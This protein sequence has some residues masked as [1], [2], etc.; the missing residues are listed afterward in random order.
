MY[1]LLILIIIIISMATLFVK[2]DNISPKEIKSSSI[3]TSKDNK[4]YLNNSR[5]V[6][7]TDPVNKS[8]INSPVINLQKLNHI[9]IEDLNKKEEPKNT[10]SPVIVKSKLR[11]MYEQL[12][13]KHI[14]R[15]TK[16]LLK[17]LNLKIELYVHIHPSSSFTRGERDIFLCIWDNINNKVFDYD[18]IFNVYLHELSHVLCDD[19]NVIG[20]PHTAEF[21]KIFD[22][23]TL[24]GEKLNLFDS[25]KVN[26]NYPEHKPNQK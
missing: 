26:P 12:Y 14:E 8:S 10:P 22:K 2:K 16:P 19:D 6:I 23:L 7:N 18:T 15:D 20:D 24:I 1:I 3:N 25:T 13:L 5:N 11:D 21:I 4:H 17:E 9:E